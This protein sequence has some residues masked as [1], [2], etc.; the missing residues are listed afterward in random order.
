MKACRCRESTSH[1]PHQW[2]RDQVETDERTNGREAGTLRDGSPGRGVHHPRTQDRQEFLGK[3]PLMRVEHDGR[4]LM[5]ASQGGSPKH[6]SWYYNLKADP[7]A[8]TVQDGADVFEAHATELTG[9]EREEWWQR[10]VAA[11][12]SYATYQQRTDRV[13]PIFLVERRE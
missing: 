5:V 13:I 9:D 2:V 7:D 10:A 8:L 4:Y 3:H 12:P 11:Y 1:S 6:P